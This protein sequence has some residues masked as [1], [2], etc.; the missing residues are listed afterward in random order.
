MNGKYYP[1][2]TVKDTHS[3][4]LETGS[5]ERTRTGAGRI[6]PDQTPRSCNFQLRF[7]FVCLL[8]GIMGFELRALVL[9]RQAHRLL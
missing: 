7:L 1:K 9:V 3:S 6:S 8:F 4:P 2:T 5:R